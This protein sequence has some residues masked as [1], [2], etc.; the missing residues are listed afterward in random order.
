MAASHRKEQSINRTN[1]DKTDAK[2]LT[3]GELS[4]EQAYIQQLQVR[5][6]S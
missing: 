2:R 6:K 1:D 5:I 3:P 4:E